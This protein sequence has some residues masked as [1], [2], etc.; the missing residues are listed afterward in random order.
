MSKENKKKKSNMQDH[1]KSFP[2]NNLF[3]Y[4]VHFCSLSLQ[5]F[6]VGEWVLN[7]KIEKQR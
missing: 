1:R 3:I 5:S 6:W 7:A 2:H 4:N